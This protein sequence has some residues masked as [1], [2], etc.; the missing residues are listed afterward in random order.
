MRPPPIVVLAVSFILRPPPPSPPVSPSFLLPT[1]RCRSTAYALLY[2]PRGGKMVRHI[3]ETL[4]GVRPYY[5][6][7]GPYR[8][9]GV[10]PSNPRVGSFPQ[11][12]DRS[13]V[14]FIFSEADRSFPTV[15]VMRF[16]NVLLASHQGVG[17]QSNLSPPKFS[18][19]PAH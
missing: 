18:G 12:S 19:V 15:V 2:G 17:A 7:R 1:L 3:P 14:H 13:V 9:R 8:R 11:L 16:T 6:P 5:R 10:P 4:R